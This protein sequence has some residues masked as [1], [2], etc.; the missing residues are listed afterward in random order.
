MLIFSFSTSGFAQNL[1]ALD[2]QCKHTDD[3]KENF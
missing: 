2:E 3:R 1:Q